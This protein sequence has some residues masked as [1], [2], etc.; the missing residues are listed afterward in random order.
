MQSSGRIRSKSEAAIDP[1]FTGGDFTNPTQGIHSGLPYIVFVNND[2]VPW[3]IALTLK[4]GPTRQTTYTLHPGAIHSWPTAPYISMNAAL[5]SGGTAANM[6]YFYSLVEF[7]PTGTPTKIQGN[8]NILE[9]EHFDEYEPNG[10]AV[11]VAG[12]VALPVGALITYSLC[13][14]NDIA[15]A[16]DYTLLYLVG[17]TTGNIYAGVGGGNVAISGSFAMPDVEKLDIVWYNGD[18][19]SH[20]FMAAWQGTTP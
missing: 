2:I 16:T 13:I 3:V 7:S 18:T 6:Q 1:R 8:Q 20:I 17:H 4:S 10:G 5:P 14:G 12:T 15:T 9:T 19:A 11:G